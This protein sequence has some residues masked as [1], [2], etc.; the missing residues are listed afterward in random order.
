MGWIPCYFC[1][2]DP[3]D[4]EFFVA[5]KGIFNKTPQLFKSLDEIKNDN[6]ADGL[7]KYLLMSL[8]I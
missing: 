3:F 7:K 1:G 8:N 5:K 6:I 2:P 4:G